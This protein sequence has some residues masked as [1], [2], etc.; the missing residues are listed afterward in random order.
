MRGHDR[1]RSGTLEADDRRTGE[2]VTLSGFVT[3]ALYIAVVCVYDA[4]RSTD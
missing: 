3:V 4:V 2:P 1:L